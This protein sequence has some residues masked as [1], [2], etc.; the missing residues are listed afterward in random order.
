MGP[1]S[2]KP[3]A[4]PSL[5]HRYSFT[6]AANDS[7]G[8]V[9]GV[10]KNGAKVSGGKLVLDNAGKTS[11]DASLAYLEF[12]AP[13]IPKSGSVSIV[14]WFM[15]SNTDSFARVI[16]FGDREGDQGRR[17][18]YF[19]PRNSNDDARVAITAT[20]TSAKTFIDSPRLD[21]AKTH[22]VAIVIDD[23]AKKLRLFVDGKEPVAAAELGENVLS[24]V[25]PTHS[26]IGKSG[27][28]QDGAL[29][30]ALEEL[31]V[32]SRAITPN[33]AAELAKAGPDLAGK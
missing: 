3:A 19:T 22:M 28:D 21:D 27:F 30:A 10:L 14:F 2:T 11:A 5:I 18:I 26:W 9:D 29:S 20:D 17:F 7:V 31:R 8:K 25:R 32:Y 24:A 12:P 1:A 33:E 16:D 23:A 15:A 6:D 4:D 13:I